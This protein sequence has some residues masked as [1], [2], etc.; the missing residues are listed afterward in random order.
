MEDIEK[1]SKILEETA[2]NIIRLSA[3]EGHRLQKP[4]YGF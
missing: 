4:I 2:T 3:M 1:V